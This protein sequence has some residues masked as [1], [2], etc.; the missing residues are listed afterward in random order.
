MVL[1]NGIFWQLYH[2]T[3]GD[4]IK[5]EL[6]FEANLIEDL[7][8]RPDWL[9]DTLS[10]L[11]K[12]SVREDSLNTYYEQQ[13]LLNPKNIVNLLLDEEVLKKLRQELNRKAPTRID[14]TSVFE[15]VRDVLSQEAL[16]DAGDIV[17]PAK[18]RHRRKQR[19]ADEE[20]P[21]STG[22]YAEL[23]AAPVG[24]QAEDSRTSVPAPAK[25]DT[26]TV[27]AGI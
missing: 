23:P 21:E 18:R 22:V 7:E 11:N 4:S 13:K 8:Q 27:R 6:I 9:W 26:G 16:A 12:R 1:T 19:K 10:V 3:F 17:A 20:T 24:A 14:L 5:H 25:T 15:A 2:L